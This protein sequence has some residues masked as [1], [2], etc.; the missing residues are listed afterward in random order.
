[1]VGTFAGWLIYLPALPNWVSMFQNSMGGSKI[2]SFTLQEHAFLWSGF[3]YV[4]NVHHAQYGQFYILA[5]ILST[6]C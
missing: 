4:R 2:M 5:S 3:Q 1:M 6:I